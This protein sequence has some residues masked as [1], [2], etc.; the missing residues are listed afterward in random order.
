MEWPSMAVLGRQVLNKES[1]PVRGGLD[2]IR[3]RSLYAL[4]VALSQRPYS[5]GAG[6]WVDAAGFVRTSAN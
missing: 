4:P 5:G 3:C 2:G 6:L 1:S